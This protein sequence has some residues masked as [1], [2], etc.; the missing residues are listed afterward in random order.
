MSQ[1]MARFAHYVEICKYD[2]SIVVGVR[3]EL[4]AELESLARLVAG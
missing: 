3:L 4:F 2:P 1:S